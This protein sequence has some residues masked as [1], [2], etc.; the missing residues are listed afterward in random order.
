VVVVL[1]GKTYG[2]K[3]N[4]WKPV[5]LRL[6]LTCTGGLLGKRPEPVETAMHPV[7][8]KPFIKMSKSQRW[9]QRVVSG[10]VCARA[11]DSTKLLETL[12]S[13]I[14]GGT[15]VECDGHGDGPEAADALMNAL[16]YVETQPAKVSVRKVKVD[17]VV[18]IT[19]PEVCPTASVH[20]GG[21]THEITVWFRSKRCIWLS[22]E[23]IEWAVSWLRV[24]LDTLGVSPVEDDTSA[25]DTESPNSVGATS[26]V[27]WSFEDAAW[28]FVQDEDQVV[29]VV[30]LEELRREDTQLSESAF[31]VITYEDRK[32]LTFEKARGLMLAGA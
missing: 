23:D 13:K 26:V 9:L 8:N 2:V 15:V 7:L 30:R 24:E 4:Q 27:R 11:L 28:S 22:Q 31:Q 32:R 20:G 21:P 18:K 29:R 14:E 3:I 10:T 19:M 5:A 17:S 25:V 1:M 6:Q 12:C 16:D